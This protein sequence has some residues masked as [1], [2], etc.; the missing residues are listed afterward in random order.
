MPRTPASGKRKRRLA[1]Q[2]AAELSQSGQRQ[3]TDPLNPVNLHSDAF[4]LSPAVGTDP[5]QAGNTLTQGAADPGSSGNNGQSGELDTDT[6]QPNEQAEQTQSSAAHSQTPAQ[7]P[8]TGN[9]GGA[10]STASGL[11]SFNT[12]NDSTGTSSQSVDASPS[13]DSASR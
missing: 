3:L 12:A 11:A 5:P 1:A 4:G 9:P 8:H 13:A 10:P 2:R 7:L 6:V